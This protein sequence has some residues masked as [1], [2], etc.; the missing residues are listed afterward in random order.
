MIFDE[1]LSLLTPDL[2]RIFETYSV[3]GLSDEI[4]TFSCHRARGECWTLTKPGY[5]KLK[6]MTG[7]LLG[8]TSG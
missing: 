4:K 5:R 7:G 6:A 1:L 2:L 3:V 8:V